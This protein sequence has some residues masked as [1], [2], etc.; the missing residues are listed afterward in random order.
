MKLVEF[1]W[2]WA[3]TLGA[4]VVVALAFWRGGVYERI[5]AALFLVSLLLT[6]L[7]HRPGPG[8][9]PGVLAIDATLCLSC[10]G[11]SLRARRVWTLL[12]AAFTL[13]TVLSHLIIFLDPGLDLYTYATGLGLWGGYGLILAMGIGVWEHR[14]LSRVTPEI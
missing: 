6:W 8:F 14:L 5:G 3:G 4:F 2:F 1:L 13:N 11:L 12:M 10:I 9:D 7:V